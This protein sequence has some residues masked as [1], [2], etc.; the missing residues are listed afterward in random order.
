MMGYTCVTSD[1]TDNLEIRG[2][3]GDPV[4][5]FKIC[6]GSEDVLSDQTY[7]AF[8]LSHNNCTVIQYTVYTRVEEEDFT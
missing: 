7:T 2:V 8:D 3:L 4:E 1:N 6:K 5:V